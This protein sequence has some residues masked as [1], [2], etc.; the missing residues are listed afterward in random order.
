MNMSNSNNQISFCELRRLEVISCSDG[1]KLG[2]ILDIIFSA[3]TGLIAGI[4]TPYPKQGF[5][6]RGQDLFI[7]WNCV[8]KLG[9]DVII[10]DISALDDGQPVCGRGEGDK[11]KRGE[12]CLPCGEEKH[13]PCKPP[14]ECPPCDGRCEKCMLFDC[15]YRWRR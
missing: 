12:G 7:P 13:S 5:F 6:G 1:R 2:K 15:K 14:S 4:V 3:N 8:Q 9:Q 11:R 10:V